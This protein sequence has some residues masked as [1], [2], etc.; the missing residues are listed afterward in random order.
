MLSSRQN[1]GPGSRSLIV[2]S[3]MEMFG[4]KRE[5]AAELARNCVALAVEKLEF[6]LLTRSGDDEHASTTPK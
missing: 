5:V 4:V 6:E 2:E 1:T 3:M